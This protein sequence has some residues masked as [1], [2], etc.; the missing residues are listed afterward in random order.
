MTSAT[1]KWAGEP[2]ACPTV[3]P[4]A[5]ALRRA[6]FTLVEIMVVMAIIVSLFAL[7][8][9]A[10]GGILSKGSEKAT[11]SLIRQLQQHLDEYKSRTGS[12]PPDG[13][14]TPVKNDEGEPIRGSACLYHFLTRPVE[15]SERVGGRVTV[16]KTDPIASFTDATLMPENEDHPGVRELKDGWGNAL[17]YDNTEDGVF[18]AQGGDVHSPPMD[19][20]EHPD[21]PRVG[22]FIVNGQNAVERP[23]IQG[24]GYDLWSHGEQTHDEK[25][26]GG[27]PV[28]TWNLKD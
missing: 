15:V 2:G 9:I 11:G 17:H 25:K 5:G 13:I 26:P 16:R 8:A 10:A 21:D 18:R 23:G 20:S 22:D 14:D 28:A 19:D 7:V 6:G 27:L 4:R 3:L 12:F 1:G 24:K